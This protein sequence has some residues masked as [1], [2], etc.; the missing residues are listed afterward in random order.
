[1]LK[2]L[3]GGSRE[4]IKLIEVQTSESRDEYLMT[5]REVKDAVKKVKNEE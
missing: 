3:R 5:K 4:H 1:M 2:Q